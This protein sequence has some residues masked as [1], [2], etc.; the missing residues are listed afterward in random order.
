LGYQAAIMADLGAEVFSV[1]V[2]EEFAEAAESRFV[3]L[4]YDVKV[5]VGDGARGWAEHAP[6]DAILVTAA[7]PEP[8]PELVE[9]LRPGGR[10]VVPLG[11]PEVQQ[12]SLVEKKA[13][14]SAAAR[15]VMAVKFTQLELTG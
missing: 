11:G 7:A 8:P 1:E 4:G 6:Y 12:L 14:G 2:V 3:A 9:Q 15:S 13:D 5:R 10:M